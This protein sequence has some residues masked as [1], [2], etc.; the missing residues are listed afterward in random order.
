MNDVLP[1]PFTKEG[2]LSMLDK[3]L[4]HLKK[5]PPG[6]DM[7]SS[8]PQSVMSAK[9]SFRSED[10]PITSPATV[11]NNWASPNNNLTGVSP[12]SQHP[13][14]P[15]MQAVHNNAGPA[16]YVTQ[17]QGGM[18]PPNAVPMYTTPGGPLAGPRPLP[19]GG[20]PA[21]HRRGISDISGGPPEMIDA[22]RQQIYT[23]GPGPPAAMPNM[24]MPS[25]GL[26]RPR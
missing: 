20:L 26:P 18:P 24:P 23:P 21:Q 4:G 17:S 13:D 15:Y 6:I 12:A 14:D 2:L 3:H 8:G 9:R 22:K 25:P 10:S 1:K 19:P 16:P 11:N 7:H 5:Q